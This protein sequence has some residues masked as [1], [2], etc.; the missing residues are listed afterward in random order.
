MKYP[1]LNWKQDLRKKLS[2]A[3]IKAIKKLAGTIPY[4]KIAKI[5]NVSISTILYHSNDDYRKKV[6]DR[7][8]DRFKR[9]WADKEFRKQCAGNLTNYKHDLIRRNPELVA[10]RT[11][12]DKNRR[13]KK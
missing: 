13:R 10:W 7:A 9:K 6:I 3:Q 11:L 8:N 2:P 1:R 12:L 5:Y 4:S